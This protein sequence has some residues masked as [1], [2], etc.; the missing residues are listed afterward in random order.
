MPSG[1]HAEAVAEI[2]RALELEPLGAVARAV[3][4]MVLDSAGLTDEAL[5]R[6]KETRPLLQ[7]SY[8]YFYVASIVQ[9]GAECFDDAK[10]TAE[11][12]LGLMPGNPFLLTV[13][14]AVHACRGGMDEVARIRKRM[15]VYEAACGYVPGICTGFLDV[16]A[17]ESRALD[18]LLEG[19]QEHHVFTM[20]WLT[21]RMVRNCLSSDQHQA[22]LRKMKLA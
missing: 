19:V 17:G 5:K 22:L 14:A 18:V 13:L 4:P 10:E 3:E 2:R 12:A 21:S 11:Y 6:A 16:L 15:D 7:N 1:R 20:P 8:L 9:A